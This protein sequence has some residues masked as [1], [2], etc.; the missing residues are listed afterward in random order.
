MRAFWAIVKLTLRHAI[1]SHI[2]QLLAGLLVFCVLFIPTT[3][4]GG[5]ASEF[6]RVSL[7]YSFWAVSI[8]LA[9]SSI[10][11]G[12]FAMTH[13]VDSYQLHMVVCKPVSRT[14]VWLAK[15]TGVNLINIILLVFSTL[16]IYCI[17]QYRFST[18]DFTEEERNKIRNEVMTGRRVF[19][20]KKPDYNA[21]TRQNMRNKIERLKAQGAQID[22]SAAGQQKIYEESRMEVVSQDSEVKPGIRKTWVF[23]NLPAKLEKPIFLRYRTYVSKVSSEDQRMTR[24]FWFLGIPQLSAQANDNVFNSQKKAAY[25][26][27]L[28]PLAQ[29]PEQVMSGQFHEKMLRPEWKMVT[30]DNTVVVAMVN[31]D[32]AKATQFFQPKDGPKL[33][34]EV[35]GFFGNYSKAVLIIIL[36]LLILSGFA[37][38]FGGCMSMPTAIFVE[39]AYLLFGSFSVYMTN[40]SYLNGAADQIGLFVAKLLLIVVIPLQAFEHT[41]ALAGGELIEWSLIWNLFWYYFLCRAVPLLLLGIYFYRR[42]ELGLVIRK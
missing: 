30:P 27:M 22:T 10:W 11:L 3:V 20:P 9:L 23:E 41:N 24:L 36:E 16:A 8:V 7:L 15:W 35:C 37:C 2:F 18:E 33:L 19:M 1:R 17:I 25:D 13:D 28:Y 40:Q 21:L 29:N 32:D 39:V 26:I 12:C 4:G 5:T 34:I 38:A 31:C 6:I 42:R 14:T